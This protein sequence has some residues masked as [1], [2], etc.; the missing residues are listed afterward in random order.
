MQ[1][2]DGASPYFADLPPEI[3]TDV[4]LRLPA[5]S[6]GRFRCVSNPFRSMLSNPGF[7]KKHLALALRK[8]SDSVHGK[9]LV[10]SRHLH[11]VD[12]GSIRDGSV[13][14]RVLAG[15]KELSSYGLEPATIT[16]VE[17]IGSSNGLVSIYTEK[18]G[19]FL[20]N[21]TTGEAK[22]LPDSIFPNFIDVM[23]VTSTSK[24][25]GFGFDSL[26][27]DYKLLKFVPSEEGFPCLDVYSLKTNSWNRISCVP[28]K[29]IGCNPGLE[30]NGA[31]HW[32]VKLL[33]GQTPKRDV[34]AAFDLNTQDFRFIPLPD[35]A[36]DCKCMK[37]A[38]LKGR[39]YLVYDSIDKHEAMW[40]MNEYGV[41]SSWTKIQL[42]MSFRS[43]TPLWSAK[44]SEEVLVQ[45]D[46]KFVLYNFEFNTWK[47]LEFSNVTFR[48]MF[49]AHTYVESLISPNSYGNA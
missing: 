48:K 17:I 16:W 2:K 30:I 1:S 36:E 35:E 22:R 27:D 10:P 5:K 20:Y 23:V 24:H 44:N 28:F 25:Y 14:T 38:T 6:V 43:F 31:V 15:V 49:L 21:P 33:K 4:C 9:L 7:V 11:S 32:V 8:V 47:N 46:G 19:N 34:V 41:E 13:A 29:H 45:V 40:V 42:S 37:V 26:T 39:L 12:L 18:A 3:V